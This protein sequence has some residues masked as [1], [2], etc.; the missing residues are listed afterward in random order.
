MKLL[1][2]DGNSI[3]NRAF[4]AIK[5]L[6]APDGLHTGGIYGFLT[7]LF[8]ALDTEEP[9]MLTVAFDV[10]APT[11]RHKAYDGYKKTRHGMPDELAEQLPVLKDVLGAMNISVLEKPGYEA[12]DIIGTV[13]AMCE[14]EGVDCRI[15]TGDRDDLQL[16]SEKTNVLLTTTSGGKTETC[17][18]DI[19][20]VREKYGVSPQSLIEVKGLMG[21]SS[22]NI[23]GVAGVGEKTALSLITK[24]GTIEEVYAH[25]DEIRGA[26]SEKL[27]RGQETA[28]LSRMLGTICREVPME[29]TLSD[30]M[31]KAPDTEKVSALFSRLRFQSLAEKIGITGESAFETVEK[32]A[33]PYK[34]EL[35]NAAEIYLLLSEGT[36][37]FTADEVVY[38]AEASEI[39]P[40]LKNP[41]VK[42]IC[43]DIKNI[44]VCLWRQGISFAGGIFDTALAAYLLDPAMRA[45][46]IKTLSETYLSK[47]AQGCAGEVSLLRPL[48]EALSAE[49]EKRGQTALYSDLELP[50]AFVLADMEQTGVFAAGEKL[51]ALSAK[52]QD[53]MNVLEK[54][55]YELSGETFNIQSPKQL[56]VILFEKLGLPAAKKTK[57]GYSTDVAVLEKLI[58]KHE[59]IENILQYRH[60]SKLKSTYADGLGT[61]IN[62]KT[63]R[64]HSTFHQTVTATGRISSAD[65][66]L[67][68]IPV[69]TALGREIRKVF[70]AKEDYLL[71]DADYSQIELRVLAHMAGDKR[72]QEAFRHGEDIHTH[73]AAEIFGVPEFM[74]TPDMRSR[75]K[76]I[77]FG[78]VYGMSDFSLAGNLKIS[79][80]EASSYIESYMKTYSGVA[81]FMEKA[82]QEAKKDGFVKTILNRRRY[83]PEL[84]ASN[85]N[86]RAFG[87]RV[88]MN[89]PIQGSAADIIKLAMLR[90]ADALEKGA[91]RSKLI[92]QVHDELIVEAHP[93]EV[94]AVQLIMKREMENAYAL[95]VPLTVDI[96]CGKSWYDAK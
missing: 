31:R 67:Q 35:D 59:I 4:Y 41:N 13:A 1:I 81:A 47:S 68:N 77:N 83:V 57:S 27:R 16:I 93:D 15:L 7:T 61:F 6:T 66:N 34:G 65:P 75:A 60:V 45:Y 26:L 46:D 20:A 33:I 82:I 48:R 49:M 90:V 89:A 3:L 37:Y 95:S 32:E 36:F 85:F 44:A 21:D 24:Y 92:L 19:A 62:E 17:L 53:E 78:I 80:K 76:T 94:E 30:F 25:I 5:N 14:K 8:K 50:L 12:D 56:G 84:R 2:I 70:V 88:A 51:S 18:Y 38:Q 69:R 29:C 79:R 43:H 9:D 22:D 86:T 39:M 74:V 54:N 42:K 28:F 11:F 63:G 58:G 87:E 40:L 96:G 52:L 71:V 10:K 55:I 64:I 73:T 23:P 91:P 72:M